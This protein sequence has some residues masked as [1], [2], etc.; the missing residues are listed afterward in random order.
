VILVLFDESSS[1]LRSAPQRHPGGL[2]RDR[3]RPTKRLL[4]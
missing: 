4:T 1:T 3:K 2:A